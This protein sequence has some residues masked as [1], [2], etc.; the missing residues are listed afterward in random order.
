VGGF[1]EKRVNRKREAVELT[2]SIKSRH[3]VNSSWSA[4][5]RYTGKDQ[6]RICIFRSSFVYFSWMAG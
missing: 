1:S 3:A 6:V 5:G 2:A 4:H